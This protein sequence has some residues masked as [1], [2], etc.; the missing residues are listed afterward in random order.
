[1]PPRLGP[2]QAAGADILKNHEHL[3]GNTANFCS[4]HIPRI[5][6]HDTLKKTKDWNQDSPKKSLD[7]E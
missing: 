6:M 7:E 1:M 4:P 5:N 3:K 2:L